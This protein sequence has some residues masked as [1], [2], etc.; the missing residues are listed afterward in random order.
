[1]RMATLASTPRTSRFTV[2]LA[3]VGPFPLEFRLFDSDG[4]TVFVDGIIRSDWVLSA[5]FLDGFCDTAKISFLSPLA[6]GVRV[7]ID[8]S[9]VPKR[10]LDYI[11]GDPNF[12][13]KMNVELAR[14]WS[15]IAETKMIAGRSLRGLNDNA[16]IIDL[17]AT[18]ITSIPASRDQAAASAAASAASAA[19]ALQKENSMIRDRGIWATAVLFKPSDTFNFGGDVYIT[20]T[21]HISVSVPTDLL[22][23]RIRV[24]LLKGAPGTGSGN[25]N[26]E[27]NFAFLTNKPLAYA[28]IGGRAVGKVNLVPFSLMDPSAI[29]SDTETL[30]ANPSNSGLPTGK[31]VVDYV[32]GLV[33]PASPLATYNWTGNVSA[34]PFLNLSGWDSLQ[35]SADLGFVGALAI[36]FSKDNGVTW[37]TANYS[38]IVRDYVN[39]LSTDANIGLSRNITNFAHYDLTVT[40]FDTAR[41]TAI[42]GGGRAIANGIGFS[43]VNGMH[44]IGQRYNALRFMNANI[45]AGYIEIF[46]VRRVLKT[47]PITALTLPVLSPIVADAV[48]SS[49]YFPGTYATTSGT[50]VS[51]VPTY[52]VNG[53]EQSAS[54]IALAGDVVTVSVLV[55]NSVGNTRTFS[56]FS[57][58][59]AINSAPVVTAI[60]RVVG[61]PQ[62]G[63]VLTLAGYV[64]QG[65]GA[66]TFE[67]GWQRTQIDI[68]LAVSATYTATIADATYQVRGKVRAIDS[69]GRISDWAYSDPV[70]VD[71]AALT[72]A[73]VPS[74]NAS[75]Y[76]QGSTVVISQ[77]ALSL[78]GTIETLVF[79][80]NGV[81]KR[82]ELVLVS[83]GVYTWNSGVTAAGTILFQCRGYN[84]S[85]EVL[86]A[87]VTRPLTAPSIVVPGIMATGDWGAVNEGSGGKITFTVIT[88]PTNGGTAI[89]GYD[90]QKDGTTTISLGIAAAGD[91][92]KSGFT[93]GVAANYLIRAVNS[94]G[95]GP[96]SVTN[97][98]VTPSDLVAPNTTSLT[99]DTPTNAIS[100]VNSE[101][102]K[103]WYL[104]EAAATVHTGAALKALV[105]AATPLSF[106]SINIGVAEVTPT[107]TAAAGAYYIKTAGEDASGNLEALCEIVLFDWPGV[108]SPTVP[109]LTLPTDTK[110]GS[111]ACNG[112]VSAALNNGTL[113]VV[114]STSATA[115]SAAQMEAGQMHTGAAAPN[116]SLAVSIVGVQNVAISGLA[117]LTTYY[118]HYFQRSQSGVASVVVSADGFT[119]DAAVGQVEFVSSVLML[120]STSSSPPG[121]PYVSATNHTVSSN[122]NRVTVLKV[123]GTLDVPAGG[124]PSIVSFTYGGITPTQVQA[125]SSSGSRDWVATYIVIGASPGAK[126]CS[127][128]VSSTQRA[129]SVR[130]DEY[131]NVNQ[132]TPVEQSASLTSGASLVNTYGFSRTTVQN[133]NMLASSINLASG[134]HSPDLTVSADATLIAA[135]RTGT[136]SS[137]DQSTASAYEAVPTAGANG[138]SYSWITTERCTLTWLELKAA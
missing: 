54:Y 71:Y 101:P 20:Q 128:E 64:F 63:K 51:Q 13:N 95:V 115:P 45:T 89:T 70:D 11:N 44:N 137:S 32:E 100:V 90:V 86:S 114:A 31:A 87:I 109:V 123:S 91:A 126:S 55:T 83:P 49:A 131:R 39:I 15:A 76:V 127:I 48:L 125:P 30:F 40:A 105:Q 135:E 35:I 29:I 75:T 46:G 60:P 25:M 134:I 85:S 67:F 111:S 22:A 93:N 99:Y 103:V 17:A 9:L 36:Q 1:M 3:T 28:N 57:Q 77:G 52:L 80:V 74:T 42:T 108:S 112:T 24:W 19:V 5:V 58:T 2:S 92:I 6:A 41:K 26:N 56:T 43:E 33:A 110:N 132:A 69:L 94:A 27:D 4:L 23:G 65:E 68:P 118:L 116:T 62:P 16:A 88:P 12:V 106:G 34:I 136:T 14:M 10:L 21:E 107:F 102:A 50:I 66:L 104:I 130:A 8:G 79:S 81:D 47:L 129:I 96:W 73:T 53:G 121:T 84:S 119:T 113:R 117:A 97:K 61:L 138:H 98:A 59:A 72:F 82:A 7:Q 122:A 120:S 37:E 38:G 18:D 133:G 124:A 78:P